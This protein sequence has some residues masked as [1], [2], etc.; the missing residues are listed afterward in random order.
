MW[1]RSNANRSRCDAHPLSCLVGSAVLAGVLLGCQPQPAQDHPAQD[2]PEVASSSANGQLLPKDMPAATHHSP[3][4]PPADSPGTSDS[5]Q[6]LAASATAADADSWQVQFN[7]ILAGERDTLLLEHQPISA[8]QLA[9]LAQLEGRL[10]QLLLD[11]G[12]VDA[13]SLS[14]IVMHKRL[15]HLRLRNCVLPDS[16]FEQLASSG[17]DHLRI[18]NVPQAR[19]TARGIASLAGLPKLVQLRLGGSQ[20]DDAAVAEIARLPE[21]RS[22]HLIGPSLSDAALGKLAQAPKL[23]S[24]YVDDCQLSDQAWEQLFEA[25]PKLHVHIDQRHHDRDPHLHEH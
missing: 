12:G 7:A 6:S 13:A 11:A 17:L 18:L 3:T 15:T 23:S 20:I 9:Q 1:L 4:L 25:K 2:Q 22:L 8:Q 19:I 21:L 24:L 10:E 14:T 5:P 16:S